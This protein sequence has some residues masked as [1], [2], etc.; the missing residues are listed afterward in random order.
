M[1]NFGVGIV[2]TDVWM[3]TVQDS[4]QEEGGAGQLV[5]NREEILGFVKG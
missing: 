5:N 4:S 1:N 3:R 2:G